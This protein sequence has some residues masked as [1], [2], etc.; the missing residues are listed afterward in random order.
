MIS[1]NTTQIDQP[2]IQNIFGAQSRHRLTFHSMV[3]QIT[4]LKEAMSQ[5]LQSD[6][7][8]SAGNIAILIESN[9]GL[10]QAL[11]QHERQSAATR[12]NS[13]VEFLFPLQVAEVRKA[14]ERGGLL[15]GGKIDEPATPE[16]LTIPPDEGGAPRDLPKTFTPAT[17]A[18]LDEMALTQVLTTIAR[19]PY[20][21]VG[22]VATDPFDVVFLAREVRRFCPNVRL[23]TTCSDLLLARATDAVDL[24]GT[25][26]ASTYPLY[27]ANQWM[28]TS[29]RD[30]PRVFFSNRAA[31]GF[32]N[33]TA[34]HLWEMSCRL[35]IHNQR[36]AARSS[37]P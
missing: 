5:Y 16:K 26:V 8:H 13:P 20:Q 15:R 18:A 12:E 34:A 11:V 24:R 1:S 21:A 31:Q 37:T 30:G 23:F 3:H 9:T 6:L 36:A 22:I 19:R 25:L 27:P 33:A 32:Y 29:F 2:R 35:H 4:V 7:R 17:S 28:T 14:Y 10:A